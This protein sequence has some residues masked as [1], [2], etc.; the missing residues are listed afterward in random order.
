MDLDTG[1]AVGPP[2]VHS[3]AVA[4]ALLAWPAPHGV[5]AVS[6]PLILWLLITK[7]TGIPYTEAQAVRSR[8][9]R[10]REYQRTT[11]AFFPWPPR[12]R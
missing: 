6:A 2:V 10:Y 4:F 8:G 11:S 3:Q 12:R 9:E 7:V 5:V 1:A